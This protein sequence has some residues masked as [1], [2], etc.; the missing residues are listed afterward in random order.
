MA[1]FLPIL[2]VLCALASPA[3]A[4]DWRV[5]FGPY[6]GYYDFDE[7]TQFEDGGMFGFRLGIHR[8]HWFRLEAEFDEVYTSRDPVGNAARQV[9]LALHGRFEPQGWRVAPSALLGVGM[10]MLDDSDYPDAFGEGYDL[11]LG[12]AWRVA[13]SWKIR[14]EWVARYQRF[15]VRDPEAAIDDPDAGSER[16]DLWGHAYRVGAFYDLPQE[17]EGRPVRYPLGLG[18]YVGY[19]NFSSTFRYEDDALFGLRAE[20]GLWNW[21]TLQLELEQIT[22]SNKRTEDWAQAIAFA[23]HG[24]AELRTDGTWRPGMVFGVSFM[25]LDSTGDIDSISEGFDLGP[26][27]RVRGNDR[28]GLQADWL[29]RYQSV[30]LNRAIEEEEETDEVDYVWS[31]GLRLGVNVAF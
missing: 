21:F 19:W 9:T 8:D 22:T 7:I 17:R 13:D 23:M 20:A 18:V 14:G 6:L 29:F 27:V 10:V 12:V 1:R 31:S 4:Q 3:S 15:R 16:R 26:S 5:D 24:L 2:L 11:G 25:G 28:I 30:R